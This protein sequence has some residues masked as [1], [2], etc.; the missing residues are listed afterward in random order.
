MKH[1]RSDYDG[2]Q[3]STGKIP[4][5]EPVFLLRGKDPS[6]AAAVRAWA[7]D[8][9]DRGGNPL[10]VGRAMERAAKMSQYQ[11]K[12]APDKVVADTPKGMLR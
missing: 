8:V 7:Q 12:H 1:L 4:E 10:L 9:D 3:D 6:A 2:I 5:D 11:L